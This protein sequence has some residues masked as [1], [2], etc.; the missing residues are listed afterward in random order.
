MPLHLNSMANTTEEQSIDPGFGEALDLQRIL[1]GHDSFDLD[2]DV[3][4]SAVGTVVDR[5]IM[6]QEV[7]EIAKTVS[8]CSDP[9]KR[10]LLVFSCPPTS[11]E[12]QVIGLCRFRRWIT[13]SRLLP[14]LFIHQD[15]FENG[16]RM[17]DIKP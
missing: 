10:L 3:A 11:V 8:D 13:T 17:S 14:N 9:L 2:I 1:I 16:H 15:F 7:R 12:P 4:P 5:D 6:E